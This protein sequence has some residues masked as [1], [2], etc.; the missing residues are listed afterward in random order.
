MKMTTRFALACA[1]L[2]AF[3]P[4]PAMAAETHEVKMLNQSPNSGDLM[5]F[6]PRVLV[7]KPGDTVKFVPE[8]KGHNSASIKKA[9]PEGVKAWNG[10][11]SK[12]V[13]ITVD[14]AGY[15]GFQCSPHLVM[16]MIGLI[17]VDGEGR[18]DNKEQAMKVKLPGKAKKVWADLFKEA[19]ELLAKK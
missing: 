19:D 7:V 16:G 12:E 14:K 4:L 6:E 13:S 17:V 5:W 3:V 11:I 9:L 15:Y 2:L 8:D 10:G 18:D 1:L